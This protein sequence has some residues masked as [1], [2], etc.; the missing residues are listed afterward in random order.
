MKTLKGKLNDEVAS[1]FNGATT[2]NEYYIE[3]LSQYNN[4]LGIFSAIKD[5]NKNFEIGDDVDLA[6]GIYGNIYSIIEKDNFIFVIIL[7]D[8]YTKKGDYHNM[9]ICAYDIDK[10][11]EYSADIDIMRFPDENNH[12]YMNLEEISFIIQSLVV[13]DY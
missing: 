8:S 5:L 7:N 3:N 11:Y 1:N 12:S 2:M 10:S 6:Y 13:E 9:H 4:K